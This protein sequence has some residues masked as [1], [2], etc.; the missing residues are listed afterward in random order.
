[1]KTIILFIFLS[2]LTILLVKAI[3]MWLAEGRIS[4]YY[5]ESMEPSFN[6]E[7]IGFVLIITIYIAILV[8]LIY[9][10]Y[11]LALKIWSN[12]FI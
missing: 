5:G 6:E 12:Y 7:P 9:L 4:S 11:G 2:T 10:D 1:M 3:V 8:W